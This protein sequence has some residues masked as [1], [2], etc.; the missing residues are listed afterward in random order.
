MDTFFALAAILLQTPFHEVMGE[1]GQN[2]KHSWL[3][4]AIIYSL[5]RVHNIRPVLPSK[6]IFSSEPNDVRGCELFPN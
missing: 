6:W 1:S 4:N 5:L 2:Y 3:K